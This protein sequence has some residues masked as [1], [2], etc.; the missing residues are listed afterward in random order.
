MG[1][2]QRQLH[3]PFPCTRC[4]LPRPGGARAASSPHPAADLTE[5]VRL[6]GL[7]TWIEQ[8][9]KQ[10][11]DERGWADF[12]ARSNVAIRR[13]WTLV[14]CAFT[15]CWHARPIDPPPSPQALSALAEADGGE[16]ST[17]RA[18]PGPLCWPQ[19][20][21]HVRGWLTPHALLQRWWR[22]WSTRPPPAELQALVTAVTAGRPLNLYAPT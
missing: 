8:G 10:V 15:F 14:A 21:R 17:A 18:R 19:N 4:P 6:Y 3:Y 7:R 12:Q 11:K 22:N 9:D 2:G 1:A 5:I 20:I 13:N 16:R